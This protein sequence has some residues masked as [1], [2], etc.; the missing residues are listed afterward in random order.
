MIIFLQEH[1]SNQGGLVHPRTSVTDQDQPPP[2]S[3]IPKTGHPHVQP[4]AV[5]RHRICIFCFSTDLCL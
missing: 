1:D 2:P 4:H 3:A 5:L